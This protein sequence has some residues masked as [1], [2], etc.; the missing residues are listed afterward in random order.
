MVDGQDHLMYNASAP[1]HIATC[2]HIATHASGTH[3]RMWDQNQIQSNNEQQCVR[4]CCT[5][6]ACVNTVESV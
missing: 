3:A 6:T 4:V 5:A 1:E 2:T